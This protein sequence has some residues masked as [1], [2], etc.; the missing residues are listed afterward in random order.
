MDF[1]QKKSIIILI[2]SFTIKKSLRFSSGS[3]KTESSGKNQNIL[4]YKSTIHQ[5]TEI[6]KN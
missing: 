5:D 3:M 6:K 4:D 1:L 2:N